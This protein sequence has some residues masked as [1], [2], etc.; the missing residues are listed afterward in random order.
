M[1]LQKFLL[2]LRPT[3]STFLGLTLLITVPLPAQ[4]R[5]VGVVPH[6]IENADDLGPLA[7]GRQMRVTLWLHM[8]NEAAFDKALQDIYTPG[9]PA[10]HRWMT[11]EELEKYAP[12]ASDRKLVRDELTSQGL[13][14]I[15]D[16]NPFA[17]KAS[18]LTTSVERAFQT[19][20]NSFRKEGRTFHAN[21][22]EAHLE[23]RAG[24]LV[25]SVSG[26]NS[27]GP[28]PFLAHRTNLQTGQA[29]PPVP[30]AQVKSASG[31]L[32][33]F[34]TTHCFTYPE[35]STYGDKK[36]L[37]TGVFFGRIYGSTQVCG[38][39]PSQ[40]QSIY[41]LPAA[42]SAGVNGQ[43]QTVV[44]V[45]AYGSS[46]INSDVDLFSSLTGLPSLESSGFQILY[47]DG[48]PSDPELGIQLGWNVETSLDVEWV[49]AIAPQAAIVL[50]AMASQDDQ[51]FQ[52]AIAYATL[53]HLGNVISNSYGIPEQDRS[54][55]TLT[56][57]NQVIKLA[58]A[59]GIAVNYSTGDHGD[60]GLGTPTGAV[61]SPA[62]S[63]YATGVGGTSFS[64]PD[65]NFNGAETGWGNNQTLIAAGPT[66]VNDP[67][68]AAGN[69]GGSG[70]GE[71]LFFAKPAWQSNLPGTGRLLPDVAALADPFTGAVIVYTDPVNG[72]VA[73]SIGGTSLSCP[74]FSGFWA[75]ADQKAGHSLGQ[76]AQMASVIAGGGGLHDI[77]PRTSNVN[78]TG[79]VIDDNGSTF[80][81]ANDLAQP[82]QNTTDFVSAIWP[83]DGEFVN[84]TFGTDTSLQVTKGWD[85]VTGYGSP[86]GL[87]FIDLAARQ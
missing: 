40:V 65:S 57:Y 77:I 80:Y 1:F 70:G 2:C 11:T 58:A 22:T 50:L 54:A 25:L 41:G 61:N 3:S 8:Q 7:P 73:E 71:S 47:P 68:V 82:L 48:Q 17:V 12:A 53:H 18:G 38:Y 36:T 24:E 29:L 42:Y 6:V 85:N 63:P 20:I 16:E 87:T 46:T 31:G 69:S 14:I 23:G 26:L 9:S 27:D 55:L 83:F 28:K 5:T 49:H 62:D 79:T 86:V 39:Q 19:H 60:N 72:T 13:S 66:I 81:S 34:F 78:I 44:V 51:D 35:T 30:M 10:Y 43:G 33:G 32:S 59:A 64:I 4:T 45:D 21:V 84:L 37:P 76:A 67:P 15:E 56:T 75:L 52:D 74:I